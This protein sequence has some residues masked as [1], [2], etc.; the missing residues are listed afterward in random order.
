MNQLFAFLHHIAAFSLVSALVAEAV[1]LNEPLTAKSAR[2]IQRADLAY[3]VSA[4]AVLVAGFIRVMYLEK[5]AAYYFHSGPFLVKIWLFGAVAVLS[6]YPTIEFLSWRK[7]LKLALTPTLQHRKLQV[8]RWI[9]RVE[10]AAIVL[11]ILCA[12]IMARR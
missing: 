7:S 9:I 6:I 5:G 12:V 2:R 8:I 1:M 3:G 11:I 10:L 4:G